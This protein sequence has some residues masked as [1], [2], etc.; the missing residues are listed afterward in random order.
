MCIVYTNCF[1]ICILMIINKQTKQNN[2][3]LIKSVTRKNENKAFKR[4]FDITKKYYKL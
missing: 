2:F 3:L 1:I 4:K